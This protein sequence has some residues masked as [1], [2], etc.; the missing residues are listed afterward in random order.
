LRDEAIRAGVEGA[1][2]LVKR[3]SDLLMPTSTGFEKVDILGAYSQLL[4]DGDLIVIIGSATCR[5]YVHCE[6]VMR[7]ADVICRRIATSS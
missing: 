6:A 7:I 4:S 5:E 3:S 1:V 2:I